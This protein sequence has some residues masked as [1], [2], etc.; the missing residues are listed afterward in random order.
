MTVYKDKDPK[1]KETMVE[2]K[3]KDQEFTM[4]LDFIKKMAFDISKQAYMKEKN[5]IVFARIH[6][7]KQ[8]YTFNIDEYGNLENIDNNDYQIGANKGSGGGV[9]KIEIYSHTF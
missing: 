1:I 7:E 6:T 8:T 9:G 5:S 3:T 4:D 2:F